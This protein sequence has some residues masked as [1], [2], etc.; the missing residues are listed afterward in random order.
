[1]IVVDEI[2]D[3]YISGKFEGEELKQVE[4][5]FFKS[6]ERRK[7][8]RFALALKEH[9][10]YVVAKRKR[11]QFFQRSLAIAASVLLVGGA[12][13][14]WR[15]SSYDAELNKGLAALQS[16][17]RDERPLESRISK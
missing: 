8:L 14:I 15:T 16:A 11:K 17:Y 2:T 4:D 12:F 13:Y 9:K 7:K 3:D 1:D 10:S 6:N 5:Y